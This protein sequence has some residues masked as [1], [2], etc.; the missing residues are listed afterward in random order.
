[1]KNYLKLLPFLK[2]HSGLIAAAFVFMLATSLFE[3]VSL[4]MIVPLIDMVLLNKSVD[5]PEWA[6]SFLTS[7]VAFLDGMNPLSKLNAIVGVSIVLFVL[8]NLCIFFQKYL[9]NDVAM[10]FLRDTRNALYRHYETLSLDFF[11]GEKTGDMVSRMTSDVSVLHNTLV[12]GITDLVY[13]STRALVF[14]LMAV[15]I[16]VRLA[17]VVLLLLP[18]IGYPVVR[19]G[20][21]LRKLGVLAQQRMADINSHLI[22]TFQGIRII[23]A[24]T[25][26]ETAAARF[27]KVNQEYYKANIKTV[28][29]REALGAI[30]EIIGVAAG[31]FVLEVG[32][33]A[34]L[35]GQLSPGV[36]VLFIG[37]LMS[38][39]PPVK[40]LSRLHS[41]HQHAVVAAKRIVSILD[42]KS[43]V[44]ESPAAVDL[45]RFQ[46]EIRFEDVWFKYQD[47]YILQGI[48]LS[49]P[50]GR[51]LGIVGSSGAGKTTLL[52]LIPRFY[53]PVKGRILIDGQDIR[54]ATLRSL[55][56]QIGLVTQ[57]PFL[58][59]D[60]VRA[61]I[62]FGFPAADE[63]AIV[64]AAKAAN[65]DSFIRN[66]PNGYDTVVGDLGNRL[67]GGERQRIAIARAI[68]KDPP[69][70][71]LDEA[72]S[73]LDSES[74]LLVQEALDRLMKGRTVFVISHRF[75]AIRGA[76]QIIVLEGGRVVESGRHE[77]L[78]KDS[79]IYKRL[80]ELQ[81]AQ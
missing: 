12:E 14:M 21:A 71:I 57:D 11:G 36:F 31:L 64:A 40:K 17:L 78:L 58:F 41:I 49:I 15:L 61:N 30:T 20:K 22:E 35:S 59:N 9:M 16:D 13:N 51:V 42:V 80:Y 77:D 63:Q 23:K 7:G 5:L 48:N 46:K 47:Q 8:K 25:A 1:M 74:E 2:P 38:L 45:P 29:R 19:I 67:S 34:V 72:T 70:L 69:I 79:A 28:K 56:S 37:S 52:N 39:L 18:A 81:V 68:L 54:Q 3:G 27:G 55:R 60:T 65:A 43:T 24:F 66:L 6:P 50:A 75:S 32:G 44:A 10:K 53:D 73:Q 4:G 62:S 33:R 26:E 76:D